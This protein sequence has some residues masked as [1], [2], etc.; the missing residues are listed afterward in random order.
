MA[1]DPP[2]PLDALLFCLGAAAV[3]MTLLWALQLRSRDATSV[4]AGWSLSI[5]GLACWAA[6][7][8]SGSPLMR[9]L[10]A[11]LAL[12]WSGRL[13]LHLLV[14]RVWARK[15]EDGRYAALRAHLGP[16]AA[17]KFFWVYLLQALLAFAFA[18]PF[19]LWSQDDAANL[20]TIHVT[21]L[22]LFASGLIMEVVADRQ[23]ARHRRD[24]AGRGRA[25][26]SGLWR[27]SRH[28]NYFGEFL[29]WC[30]IA[31]LASGAPHGPWAWLAALLMFVMV[32]FV[33]GVPFA[34][35]QSLKSRGDDYRAYQRETNAFFPWLPRRTI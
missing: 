11:A 16:R 12:V 8:G 29:I 25:C 28:P 21:G 1:A 20:S 10:C 7:T 6:V 30:G 14:D 33:S 18:T 23:L 31:A 13:S 3:V 9:G 26:R 32:R 4:D 35:I 15:G 17:W 5:G 22:G 34:E 2:F 19:V 27:Y 24:P